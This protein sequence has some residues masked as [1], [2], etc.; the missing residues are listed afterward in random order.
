MRILH[1]TLKKQYFDEIIAGEKKEEYREIKPYWAK[2][3][4]GKTFDEILFKHGYSKNAPRMRVEWLGMTKGT[5]HYVIKLGRVLE[6]HPG[7]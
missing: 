7:N 1:L 2:R 6:I 5:T 3:L 4:E